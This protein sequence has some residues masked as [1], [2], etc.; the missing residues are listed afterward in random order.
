MRTWEKTSKKIKEKAEEIRFK[1]SQDIIKTIKHRVIETG[2]GNGGAFNSWMF[3]CG[4]VRHVGAYCYYI[5]WFANN[6]DNFT[7]Q[8]LKDM[9][10]NWIK[11]PAEFS[12]YCGFVELWE[13]VKEVIDVLDDVSTKEELVELVNSLWEY[14]NNLNA[15]IYH[16]IPWGVFYITPT[17]DASY[18]TNAVEHLIRQ[19]D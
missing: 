6:K 9:V 4:D 15:W 2:A 12:G 16:Y 3:S 14:S 11:Q 8:Q 18:Y 10:K 5:I 1:P 7:L 13:F 17:M 19:G